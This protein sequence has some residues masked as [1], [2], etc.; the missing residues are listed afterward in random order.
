M[1]ESKRADLAQFTSRYRLMASNHASAFPNSAE[2]IEMAYKHS[3]RLGVGTNQISVCSIHC[4]CKEESS[5]DRISIFGL[6]HVGLCTA[7]CLAEKGYH[8]VGIDPDTEK[9]DQIK[10]GMAPFDEE[11]LEPILNKVLRKGTF[12]V[13]SDAKMNTQSNISFIAVGT[14]SKKDGSIDLTFVRSAAQ[15][16]GLSLSE[17]RGYHLTVV[18]STVI[19][20]TT[21]DTVMPLIE[22]NSEKKCGIDFGLCVNPEFLREGS[23]I[24]D[25]KN[26]DRIIIGSCDTRS[27]IVLEKLYREFYGR[28]LPTL[29]RTNLPTAELMKYAN[30]VFLATRISLINTIANICERVPGTDVTQVA[31]A[32]GVDERIG[33]HFLNAG[34]GFGGSCFPKDVRALIAY[35]RTELGYNPQLIASTEE[36]NQE[37]P[38]RAVA[39]AK[40]NLG[41]LK[42][43]RIAILGLAFKPKT[44]DMRD[45]VSI[46]VINSLLREGARI[47]V[48]DPRA[49][50]RARAIFRN[51]IEYASSVSECLEETDCCIVVTEWKEFKAISPRTFARQMRRPVVIDGRR[52]YDPDRFS[53]AGVRYSAVGLGEKSPVKSRRT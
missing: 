7:V 17:R 3:T 9:N 46:I 23:A 47:I 22:A 13:T 2:R 27:R 40:M 48:Y 44:D 28:R 39:L 6:G 36:V 16:V 12:E 42:G 49:M 53:T 34:L 31:K 24:E 35:S 8:V 45:A 37:Q 5:L 1:S 4:E 10:R 25:T 11:K 30:N 43:R 41:T 20:G 21:Q 19:P 52:I 38:R 15:A 26:P 50:R 18:K 14:P 33:P 32:I 29:I 51:R